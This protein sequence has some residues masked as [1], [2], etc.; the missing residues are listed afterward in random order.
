MSLCGRARYSAK[1]RRFLAARSKVVPRRFLRPSG[2][3]GL[4]FY[5]TGRFVDAKKGLNLG[6]LTG[7]GTAS[8]AFPFAF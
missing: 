4:R 6:F 5:I 1:R 3:G 2:R 7:F 8:Q